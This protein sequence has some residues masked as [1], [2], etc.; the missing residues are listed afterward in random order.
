MHACIVPLPWH[1]TH[2]CAAV[3][4]SEA[5]TSAFG[6]AWPQI[7]AARRAMYW[8]AVDLAIETF[9]APTDAECKAEQAAIA[10]HHACHRG[11][12]PTPL[13][14]SASALH[15]RRAQHA[16]RAQRGTDPPADSQGSSS[17]G[18]VMS[19]LQ[20]ISACATAWA[21]DAAR[22]GHRMFRMRELMGYDAREADGAG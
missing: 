22:V 2:A 8:P 11:R 14:L 7:I 9:Y 20:G 3:V 18:G 10:A 21:H 1:C 5:H 16:H 12:P 13:P 19:A 6:L 4:A 15:S 17:G